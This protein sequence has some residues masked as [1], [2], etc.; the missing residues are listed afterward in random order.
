MKKTI[1]GFS[2][3]VALLTAT[4]AATPSASADPTLQSASGFGQIHLGLPIRNFAFSATKSSDGTVIGEAQLEN[5]SSGFRGHIAIDCLNVL[6]NVA[7]MS[8][9]LT[10]SNLSDLPVGT[11]EL[12]AVQDSGEG[13]SAPADQITLTFSGLGIPCTFITDPAQ[14]ALFF[15]PIESGQIQVSS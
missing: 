4:G 7:V 12:F 11:D 14:L 15:V 3:L 9:V 6:G 13:P 5:R 10:E 1:L 2:L 8:G